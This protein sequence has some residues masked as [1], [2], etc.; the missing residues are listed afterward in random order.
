[1]IDQSQLDYFLRHDFLFWNKNN[2]PIFPRSNIFPDGQVGLEFDEEPYHMEARV[3]SSLHL[4]IYLQCRNSGLQ[5][6]ST[7]PYGGRSDRSIFKEGS[8]CTVANNLLPI[9][10]VFEPHSG[11]EN[12]WSLSIVEKILR[13]EIRRLNIE[14]IA[15]PDQGSFE[16]YGKMIRKLGCDIYTFNKVRTSSGIKIEGD[17]VTKR[18]LV[19]DDLCDGGGT[20][21]SLR[22][23]LGK[24]AALYVSHGLFTQGINKILNLYQ[25]IVTTNSYKDHIHYN[26][27]KEY[28]IFRT[29]WNQWT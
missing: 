4:D 16:R 1:M 26:N 20:F 3:V 11:G 28:E 25:D 7:Y 19:V 14:V 5:T 23:Y 10:E 8:W 21:I 6:L 15:L 12:H 18:C 24:Y 2:Y 9:Q 13:E 29:F 17:P 22:P 27:F